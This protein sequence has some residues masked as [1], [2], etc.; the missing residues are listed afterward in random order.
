MN[1]TE[2][3]AKLPRVATQLRRGDEFSGPL[4]LMTTAFQIAAIAAQTLS[5]GIEQM[6]PRPISPLSSSG[7]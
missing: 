6:A 2:D 7:I 5:Q 4:N 3:I 1:L